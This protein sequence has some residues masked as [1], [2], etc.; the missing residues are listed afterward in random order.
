MAEQTPHEHLTP[1]TVDFD[2]VARVST[3]VTPVAVRAVRSH[4]DLFVDADEIPAD[5]SDQALVGFDSHAA[6]VDREENRLSVR[7]SFLAVFAPDA[8]DDESSP[9]G[10]E[11]PHLGV[12]AV[13]EVVYSAEDP[14]AFDD[15]DAEHFAFA[16][17]T[18]HAW[19]YWRE[20]A[21]S[22]TG[23][24]GVPPLVVGPYKIPSTHDPD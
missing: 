13:F 24:M 3:Q 7:C 4:A 11:E 10:D 17:G 22:A 21:H 2:R 6:G 8:P 20:L 12:E 1:Q 9:P 18:L 14:E 5:W 15:V 19:P 23:R 16:N